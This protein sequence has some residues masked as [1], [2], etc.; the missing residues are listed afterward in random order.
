MLRGRVPFTVLPGEASYFPACEEC[1][2]VAGRLASGGTVMTCVRAKHDH[3][4]DR[5]VA[6]FS[7]ALH[8][9][10]YGL[11]IE[12]PEGCR[13]LSL[14]GSSIPWSV[15]NLCGYLGVAV[16]S[17]EAYAVLDCVACSPS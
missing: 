13:L 8:D 4:A 14:E 17:G 1:E 11:L 12:A 2:E 9:L 7:M 5:R 16:V 3:Y 10:T 15:C 6:V